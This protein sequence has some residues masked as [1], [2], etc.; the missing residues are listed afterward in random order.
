MIALASSDPLVLSVVALVVSLAAALTSALLAIEAQRERQREASILVLSRLEDVRPQRTRIRNAHL[1]ADTDW[2]QVD[3]SVTKC[4][5]DVARAFDT[6]AQLERMRIIDDAFVVRFF[7]NTFRDLWLQHGLQSY[8]TWIRENRDGT[9]YWELVALAPWLVAA[10]DGHPFYTHTRDWPRVRRPWPSG[11]QRFGHALRSAI[12][13]VGRAQFSVIGGGAV[14]R[15]KI[16]PVLR[17]LNRRATITVL[18]T[19]AVAE[20]TDEIRAIA[21]ISVVGIERWAAAHDG[22]TI[23]AT[24]TSSHVVYVRA[25]ADAVKPLP[26]KSLSARRNPSCGPSLTTSRS[27]SEGSRSRYMPRT[28]RYP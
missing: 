25:L 26:S 17:K 4:F 5:D 9:H 24:P 20:F 22:A 7:A 16:L 27:S 14:A 1:G 28:R 3:A 19:A 11:L 18:D 2:A 23:I 13:A 12:W 8:V 10:A 6:V 21:P 15:D